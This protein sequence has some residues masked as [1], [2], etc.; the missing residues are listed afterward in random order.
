ME[1]RPT[2]N[3]VLAQRLDKDTTNQVSRGGIVLPQKTQ[4]TPLMRAKV[5]AV[6]PGYFAKDFPGQRIPICCR[7]GDVIL[8]RTQDCMYIDQI[9]AEQVLVPDTSIMAIEAGPVEDA[10]ATMRAVSMFM[11]RANG[12]VGAQDAAC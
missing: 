12:N 7:V 1:Y 8:F 11:S 5:L 3:A 4:V 2:F 9:K 10:K 6:G